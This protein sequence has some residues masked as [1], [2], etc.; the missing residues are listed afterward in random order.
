MQP[1]H[2]FYTMFP[3]PLDQPSGAAVLGLAVVLLTAVLMAL[4]KKPTPG[5]KLLLPFVG[6]TLAVKN[7]PCG[8]FVSR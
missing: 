7:D 4:G 8:Y 5:P 3:W 1:T 2:S 6:E